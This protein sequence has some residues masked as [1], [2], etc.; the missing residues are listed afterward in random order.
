MTS[1][2]LHPQ[3]TFLGAHGLQLF[4][5]SWYPS[6][7]RKYSSRDAAEGVLSTSNAQKR[8]T[9]SLL[10]ESQTPT[11][12]KGVL[13]IV[14]GLGEHSGRYCRIVR[15]LTDAGYA[16]FGFDNQGHGKSEGQRGHIN[17]WQDYRD[18]TQAFLSLIRQQEPTAPL[19]LMGHSLG[20]LIVLDYVLRSADSAEFAALD[21]KGLIVSAPPF[22]PTTGT[23]SRRRMILA[24]LL[25]GLLPRLS[26]SMNLSQGGLSRDP[27]VSDQAADDPLT[28]SSVT[29]RWGS[30]T[31][32]TLD[33]VKDHIDRLS[34]P[35]L[36]THG[37]ADPIISP[38]GSKEIFQQVNSPDKTLKLYPGS[39]HEPHNDLDADTVV[40]DL[41]RWIETA[42]AS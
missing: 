39:Y 29:L 31:L 38:S 32:S 23:A 42:I 25:S 22:Q 9:A 24:R 4:Y 20:G 40:S 15:G 2:Q 37:E 16:V 11:D 28:H 30:E 10:P 7:V 41:L 34:L 5:Q 18:N 14:H 13:A 12:I 36:L 35:L 6:S 8:V 19:F 21:V 26:L 1:T 3:G 33:W 27:S 17:R